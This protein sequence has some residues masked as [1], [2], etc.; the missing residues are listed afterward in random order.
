MSAVTRPRQARRPHR[1]IVVAV[2][3]AVVL[4]S[5]A[6]CAGRAWGLQAL[7]HRPDSA[8][9]PLS[10]TLNIPAFRLDVLRNG[11]VT[12]SYTVAVGMRRY[13]TPTGDFLI[14][15]LVW[16]PWWYPPD[17]PWAARDSVTPPGPSLLLVYPDVYRRAGGDRTPHAMTALQRAG[18]DTTMVRRDAIDRLLRQSAGKPGQLHLREVIPPFSTRVESRRGNSGG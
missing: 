11:R 3:V 1:H 15:S 18:I 2:T 9:G 12:L 14:S 7:D 4:G 10:V 17:A 8:A 5:L 6:L 13:A 16:N